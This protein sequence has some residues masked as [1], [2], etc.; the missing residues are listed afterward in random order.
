[1]ASGPPFVGTATVNSNPDTPAASFENPFVS[2][3]GPTTGG[4]VGVASNRTSY[5]S[6]YSLG[7]QR[8]ITSS[9]GIDIGY[10][11]NSARKTVFRYDF[12]QA[13]PGPAPIA[14]RRPYPA[15]VGLTGDVSWG[16]SHYDAMQAT[17]RKNMD[18][19][20]LSVLFSYSWSKVLG[21]AN[22]GTAFQNITYRDTRNWKS[23]LRPNAVESGPA[24]LGSDSL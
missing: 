21:N 7:L 23:R 12:N 15:F 16:S 24:R 8:A 3:T 20:G 5:V 13:V 17:V 2:T 1:M 6:Q 19:T 22:P 18:S 10:V 11:G 9:L 4:G 14:S